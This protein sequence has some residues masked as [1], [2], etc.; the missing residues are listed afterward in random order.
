MK[1]RSGLQIWT[2]PVEYV[3]CWKHYD[4]NKTTWIIFKLDDSLKNPEGPHS[5]SCAI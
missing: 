3:P 4:K 1:R 5:L 2:I